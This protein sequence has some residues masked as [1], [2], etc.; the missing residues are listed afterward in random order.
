MS[1]KK[2]LIVVGN[3]PQYIKAGII[4]YY[5]KKS[6]KYNV[7]IIDTNQHYDKNLSNYFFKNF[8]YKPKY[9]LNIGSHSNEI[10]I[11]KIIQAF[12]NF[13]EKNKYDIIIILGDTNSTA[14]TAICSRHKNLTL[15]H[16]EAGERT[17][18]KQD[19][20]EEINRLISDQCSDLLFT[21]SKDAKV[22]LLK[23]GYHS[24]NIKFI[25][26]P[27]LDLFKYF[28]KKLLNKN[29]IYDFEYIYATLH[30]KENTKPKV[31]FKLLNLLDNHELK[32][33]LPTHP[34]TKKI[35]KEHNWKPE[36]NLILIDP[37]DY[38]TSIKLLL[39]CNLVFTDSGGLKREAFFAKKLSISPQSGMPL[40]P[41]TVRSG[42]NKTFVPKDINKMKKYLN[43]FPRPKNHS[44]KS[45]GNGKSCQKLVEYINQYI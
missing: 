21:C 28:S 26:D 35:L 14:A 34:R 31:L 43:H 6:K 8:K 9:N 36:K 37:V 22:N 16:I 7:D 24:K 5:L 3:R 1:K 41:E 39:D 17:Y 20:P 23:E 44:L 18:D 2:I 30:R 38:I 10:A 4:F 19:A 29:R 32:V 12:S 15:I 40:W 45:F 11:S 42:W 27:M 13:I 33:I 25:G